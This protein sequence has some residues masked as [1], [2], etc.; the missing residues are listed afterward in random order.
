MGKRITKKEIAQVCLKAYESVLEEGK[1]DNYSYFKQRLIQTHTGCGVC[2]LYS[3]LTGDSNIYYLNHFKQYNLDRYPLHARTKA[4]AKQ[5]I[6][7]RMD[8]LKSWI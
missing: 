7:T 4:E 8:I 6:K 5:Y 2:Y 1:K 3:K